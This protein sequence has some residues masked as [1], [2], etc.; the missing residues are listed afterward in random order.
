M[1]GYDIMGGGGGRSKKWGVIYSEVILVPQKIL[2]KTSNLQLKVSKNTQRMCI[3]E[4]AQDT[5]S[6]TIPCLLFQ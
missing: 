1:G 5:F 4:L 3:P 6:F 2:N